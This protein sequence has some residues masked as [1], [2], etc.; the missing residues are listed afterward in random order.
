MRSRSQYLGVF[1]LFI[2]V[3]LAALAY[4]PLLNEM[5]IQA[6]EDPGDPVNPLIYVAYLIIATAGLL[7]LM[8]YA[9]ASMVRALFMLAIF[10]TLFIVF[11]P[12]TITLSGSWAVAETVSTA[13][14]LAFTF[15]LWN[16]PTWM[17]I[18]AIG[19]IVGFGSAAILGVSLGVVPAMVLLVALAVYDAVAVYRTKHMLTLAEGVTKLRLPILFIVPRDLKYDMSEFD[20]LDLRKDEQE[21][22]TTIMMG[23]GDAVIP[24]ILVVSAA[25]FLADGNDYTTSSLSVAF[26]TM[27]GSVIGFVLL[28]VLVSKGRPQ[29]GLPFLN[30]GAL[31]GFLISHLFI[32]GDLPF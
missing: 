9:R 29:A 11:L 1:M 8:K 23:V 24:G 27:L 10:G 28:M 32:L 14:A 25:V 30:G 26:G 12:M 19:F 21:G 18:N 5:G 31:I 16:R 13:I 2:T 20:D 3:Q 4:V 15:L 22:R 7:V 6:F 17:V